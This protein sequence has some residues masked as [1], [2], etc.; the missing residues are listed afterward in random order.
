M[1]VVVPGKQVTDFVCHGSS[2]LVYGPRTPVRSGFLDG[3]GDTRQPE[4]FL[5]PCPSP[6]AVWASRKWGIP[7]N[8]ISPK[9][10]DCMDAV[11][12]FRGYG[13]AAPKP[14]RTSTGR[15]PFAPLPGL[16]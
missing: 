8:P 11:L 9:P 6:S 14:N 12:R 7:Q 13:Y 3:A 16:G 4:K 1:L 5:S 15:P 2:F 10:H